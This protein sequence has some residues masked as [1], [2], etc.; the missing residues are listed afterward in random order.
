MIK[1][2]FIVGE[3]SGD[4]I[5]ADLLRALKARTGG[6]VAAVGLGGDAL[7][8]EGLATLFNIDLLSIVGAGAI[9]GRLPQLLW[10]LDRATAHILD[11]NP[12]VLV[13]IDSFAFSHRIARRVRRRRPALP[14]VN[15]VPPAVWAYRGGRAAAMR[16]YIDHALCLFPFEPEVYRRLGGPPATY[17][18]HPLMRNP[19]LTRLIAEA[20]L[21]DARAEPPELLILP[22]SRRGEVARLLDDFGQTFQRLKARRPELVGVI[23][24]VPRLHALIAA[25]V[26]AWEHQPRIVA[27]EAAK[28]EAF[29]R[30]RA[31]LA[32][33]GTVAL[34]LALAGVPMALAY[35]LDPLA[36]RLRHLITAWTAALPNFILDHPLVPEHF[37]EIVRPDHLE[38][39]LGRLIADTPERAAQLAGFAE[40]RR[41]MAVET[42]PGEAAAAIVLRMA[43]DGRPDQ[44]R[45]AVGT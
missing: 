14:I 37:H 23:P 22:G 8:A 7:A 10:A 40:I 30:A 5:G 38:R 6:A 44:A 35:R 39:R 29:G 26:A 20:P 18:G 19:H 17:V 33:S 42:D 31:A 3:D 11:E 16:G 32:A 28:W 13:V 34:E 43:A 21:G 45:P 15:Y 36:Y 12:D 9:V 24:A 27:D 2:G 1:V 25:R 41:R 4:R